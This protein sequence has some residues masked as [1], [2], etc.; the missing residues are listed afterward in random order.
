MGWMS[1][2]YYCENPWATNY[3]LYYLFEPQG[4]MLSLY[5]HLQEIGFMSLGCGTVPVRFLLQ[6]MNSSYITF[7]HSSLW[8]VSSKVQSAFTSLI[9]VAL[10]YFGIDFLWLI[11]H[12][13]CTVGS[14]RCPQSS[15]RIFFR[16]LGVN[17]NL[18]WRFL[19]WGFEKKWDVASKVLQLLPS[20]LSTSLA[21]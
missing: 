21:P 1:S 5:I 4:R 20:A 3:G 6:W 2:P 10:V 17:T 11:D 7:L 13:R 19:S 8:Y 12:W 15:L 9:I 16:Y 14:S 18:P